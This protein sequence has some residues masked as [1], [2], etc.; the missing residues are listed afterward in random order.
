MTS[1]LKKDPDTTLNFF[2]TTDKMGSI[3]EEEL[4]RSM[5]NAESS[6]MD[7]FDKILL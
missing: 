7:V 6:V 5:K 3:H 4:V 1:D 2:N